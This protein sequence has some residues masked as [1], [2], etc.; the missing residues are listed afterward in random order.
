[1]NPAAAAKLLVLAPIWS[2][3]LMPQD[4]L[5]DI[6]SFTILKGALQMSY[7]FTAPFK[8]SLL[9]L[10]ILR[11]HGWLGGASS[12]AVIA[13]GIALIRFS[14]GYIKWRISLTYLATRARL[15]TIF[16]ALCLRMGRSIPPSSL[17]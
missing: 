6:P 12:I 10:V 2:T 13:V 4:H 11:N 17:R 15:P 16:Q 5:I 14:R 8:D 9:T 7:S 3:A 1:M